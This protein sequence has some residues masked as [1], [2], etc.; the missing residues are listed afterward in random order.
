MR[1]HMHKKEWKLLCANFFL[2]NN[3][4]VLCAQ[5]LHHMCEY[6]SFPEPKTPP[7]K[8]MHTY[9][10]CASGGCILDKWRCNG[11]YECTDGSDEKDCHSSE[12]ITIYI[13]Q[14]ELWIYCFFL[15]YGCCRVWYSLD[16]HQCRILA[17]W[18][19]IFMTKV[20]FNSVSYYLQ[21]FGDGCCKII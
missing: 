6:L 11:A 17:I 8:C 12:Y 21:Y 9:F 3:F 7:E 14:T 13:P 10:P 4:L 16:A 18:C 2:T 1:V 19:W 5:L 20:Y 15:L